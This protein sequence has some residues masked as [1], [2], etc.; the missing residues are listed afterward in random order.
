MP[1]DSTPIFHI[2]YDQVSELMDKYET[3]TGGDENVLDSLGE[4]MLSL[5]SYM[6]LGVVLTSSIDVA[7]LVDVVRFMALNCIP[8]STLT[9]STSQPRDILPVCYPYPGAV[10]FGIREYSTYIHA[11]SQPSSKVTTLYV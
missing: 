11:N 8:T 3:Y 7:K 5:H 9:V 4:G 10:P 6:R 1:W 2:F